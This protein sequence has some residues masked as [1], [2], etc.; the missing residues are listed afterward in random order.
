MPRLRLVPA[1]LCATVLVAGCSAPEPQPRSVVDFASDPAVLNGVLL[2]CA[3]RPRK[4]ASDPECV[5][6][7][8]AA[9]QLAARAATEN[10]AEREREFERLR[11][12]RRLRDEQLRRAAERSQPKF[13]P[14]RSPVTVDDSGGGAAAAPA[15]AASPAPASSAR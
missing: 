5:N 12:E 11:A 15:S 6:A 9:E 3:E 7:R 2:R 8:M 10:A 13:D 1:L 4:S 14:Y